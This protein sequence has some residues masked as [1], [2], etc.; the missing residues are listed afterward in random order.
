MKGHACTLPKLR[1]ENKLPLPSKR[2]LN[3]DRAMR[4][5]CGF[6]DNIFKLLGLKGKDLDESDRHSCLLLDEMQLDATVTFLADEKSVIGLGDR[7]KYTP[8]EDRTKQGD[9]GL[10]LMF[11]PFKGQWG[12]CVDVVTTDGAQWNRAMWRLS[13]VNLQS[14]ST[15]HPSNPDQRLWF[16]S[17]FPHLVKTL[18]NR[19]VSSKKL[20]S[21]ANGGDDEYDWM[22]I[23]AEIERSQLAETGGNRI[24]RIFMTNPFVPI[25]CMATVAALVLGLKNFYHGNH[26]NQQLMMR[27]RVGAQGFTIAALMG[28]VFYHAFKAA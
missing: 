15:E 22:H 24:T 1:R 11:Q 18:W 8:S 4:A 7:G 13:G 10:V 26:R 17:D 21:Q 5:E 20:D 6:G 9:H 27:A 12:F 23:Q 28:G 3:R 16:C 25:G 2:T 14:S 19:V